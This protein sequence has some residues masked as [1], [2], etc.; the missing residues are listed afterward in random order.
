MT[1]KIRQHI[2]KYNK[3]HGWGTDDERIIE[4][5]LEA[6]ILYKEVFNERR[7]WNDTFNVCKIG[8][9]LIGYNWAETTGDMSAEE[10]GW[11]FEPESIC[12]VVVKKVTE[13]IYIA[14]K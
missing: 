9:L 8:G 13:I 12:E 11:E 4:T 3:K 2:V 6:D 7:H 10:K 1:A 5:I 14:K